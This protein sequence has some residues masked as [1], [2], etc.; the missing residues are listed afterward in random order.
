MLVV[1][2]CD[3]PAGTQGSASASAAPT[4]SA[5]ALP[6]ASALP[7]SPAQA[8]VDALVAERRPTLVRDCLAEHHRGEG[9]VELQ[10]IAD[11]DG[12][13]RVKDATVAGGA[14]ELRPLRRCVTERSRTWRF[15]KSRE[16]GTI[17]ATVQLGPTSG[18]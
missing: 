7:S 10:L 1:S 12:D 16:G 14:A 4:S 3:E 17:T 8:D 6:L 15:P 5:S 13:G 9:G 2:G 11:V 18:G